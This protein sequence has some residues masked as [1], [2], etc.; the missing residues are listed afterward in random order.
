MGDRRPETQT[1]T[2]KAQETMS[3][4]NAGSGRN[5]LGAFPGIGDSSA[6]GGGERFLAENQGGLRR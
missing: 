4:K 2:Q 3:D 6:G 1:D 5:N